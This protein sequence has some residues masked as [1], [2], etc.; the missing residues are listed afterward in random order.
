[1]ANTATQPLP[2][3]EMFSPVTNDAEQRRS[4]KAR[5]H[6][7]T[8]ASDRRYP[9]GLDDR[10]ESESFERSSSPEEPEQ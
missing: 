1:M 3:R 8:T 10:E 2:L 7:R 5:T 4:W 9:R 6:K